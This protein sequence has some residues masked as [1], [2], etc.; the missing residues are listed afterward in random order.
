V[1]ERPASASREPEGAEL[2]R[3]KPAHPPSTAV[4]GPQHGPPRRDPLR[5]PDRGRCTTAS[6]SRTSCSTATP[7][8]RAPT[9]C[10][11]TPPRRRGAAGGRRMRIPWSGSR[12]TARE[13]WGD[14]RGDMGRYGRGRVGRL[15][16][17][18]GTSAPP[19]LAPL[20]RSWPTH[21]AP[22]PPQ[23]SSDEI[24]SRVMR[25]DLER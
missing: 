6:Y 7:W 4:V 12:W 14:I 13:I 21:A 1:L 5:C 22:P 8:D 9:T 16:C 18:D 2:E 23:I 17:G 15:V 25:S 3:E 19:T 24:R 20:A 11:T 10:T